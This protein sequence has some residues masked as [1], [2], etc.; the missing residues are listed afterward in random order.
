[1]KWN[2]KGHQFDEFQKI[3]NNQNDYYIWGAAVAG[4]DFYNK[5]ENI[6]NIKGFIDSDIKKQ[7]TIINGCRVYSFE[8]IKNLKKKDFKIIVAT[9]AYEEIYNELILNGLIENKDFCNHKTFTSV[10]FMYNYK[11]LYMNRADISITSKCT[12]NCERCNMLMPYFKNPK[13]KSMDKIKE[14]IDAYFKLVDNL[15]VLN[16]LGGEPFLYPNLSELIQY[17]GENYKNKIENIK[18]FSNGTCI[19]SNEVLESCKRYNIVIEISDYSATL[20]Y[21]KSKIDKFTEQLDRNNIKYTRNSTKEWF[22]FGYPKSNNS[23]LSDEEMIQ[24]FHKCNAPYRGIN[25]K[26]LY[27]CHLNTSAVEAGLFD[28]NKNDFFDLSQCNYDKKVELM[29]FDLGFN[30]KGFITFCRKCNGCSLD[31]KN[32]VEVAKQVN[33]KI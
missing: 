8:D 21:I 33:E 26:K 15:W 10:F 24:F 4:K 19:L 20:P 2:K 25:D 27:F 17:I 31:N 29:E 12:L 28:D 3:W 30:N 7:D 11:K 32:Y 9:S 22:D 1:M 18:F 23:S 5:F 6:I 16:I 13:H 14:D